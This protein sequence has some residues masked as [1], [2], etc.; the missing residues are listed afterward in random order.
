[1]ITD[2]HS[3]GLDRPAS[4]VDRAELQ[5]WG[6]I[7][8]PTDRSSLKADVH[9]SSQAGGHSSRPSSQLAAMVSG[10]SDELIT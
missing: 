3:P 8:T 7:P 6:S 4:A 9:S 5:A 1:M 10:R 2:G